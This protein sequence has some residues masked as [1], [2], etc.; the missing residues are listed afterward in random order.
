MLG[1]MW[2]FSALCDALPFL[3]Q[4]ALTATS[5]ELLL[6]FFSALGYI[7]F[8]GFSSLTPR[9]ANDK[10]VKEMTLE[11]DSKCEHIQKKIHC[12]FER[13][14]F[15]G[16]VTLWPMLP[17]LDS[18]A[19]LTSLVLSMAQLGKDVQ[20]IAS[21]IKQALER[22]FRICEDA[23]G[24]CQLI[25]DLERHL[26]KKDHGDCYAA[27]LDAVLSVLDG[28][29]E[30]DVQVLNV[31]AQATITAY[32]TEGN[33]IKA[34]SLADQHGLQVFFRMSASV[35][36]TPQELPDMHGFQSSTG[37]CDH[38]LQVHKTQN[39]NA[40]SA[41]FASCL[42][43]LPVDIVSDIFLFGELSDVRNCAG[44]SCRALHE[45]IWRQPDFWVSLGGTAFT[46]SLRIAGPAPASADL[47][48]AA[49]RRWV[50][51]IEGD[52]SLC[53]EQTASCG[54]PAKALRE[55]QGLVQGL[56]PGDASLSEIWR[57]IRAVESA[58]QCADASDNE[59]LSAASDLVTCCRNRLDIFGS[60]DVTELNDALTTMEERAQQQKLDNENRSWFF[61]MADLD[62][63]N[64][65]D[66][67]QDEH[68]DDLL[69]LE[70][71]AVMEE[72][73]NNA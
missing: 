65:Q 44:V 10:S 59:A 31:A 50:F 66:L 28:Q 48:I 46:G 69:S 63:E 33:I 25:E 14:D 19:T 20:A 60:V 54:P 22:N 4:E 6:L 17:H 64:N 7:L 30:V 15:H 61:S 42:S 73:G 53:L 56:R 26:H 55:A 32:L 13:S 3:L 38:A 72:H 1:T 62:A 39:E 51:G 16:V 18:V 5:L 27:L 71:L 70:F 23:E 24:L 67:E 8:S 11:V 68:R 58:M 49:F 47:M 9:I 57:L 34:K 41:A 52:W 29:F 45:A 36:R 37:Q 43:K 2:G 40:P 21:E 12:L 35:S